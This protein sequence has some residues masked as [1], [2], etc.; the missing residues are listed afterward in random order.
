MRKKDGNYDDNFRI[1]AVLTR[2]N[3]SQ[4]STVTLRTLL[5]IDSVAV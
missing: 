2:T 5:G 4:Y 1:A 3:E